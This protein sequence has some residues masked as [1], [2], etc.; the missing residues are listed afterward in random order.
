MNLKVKVSS[1][2]K[3]EPC[4]INEPPWKESF[5]KLNV[6]NYCETSTLSSRIQPNRLQ[7]VR[8]YIE[9]CLTPSWRT[10]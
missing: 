7:I 10:L 6:V 9:S 4:P 3:V 8:R 2:I 1:R 5:N